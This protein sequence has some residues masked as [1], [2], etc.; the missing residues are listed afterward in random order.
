M[1]NQII[2]L[3]LLPAPSGYESARMNKLLTLS[4]ELGCKCSKD[5][6]GNLVARKDA[7]RPTGQR[8]ALIAGADETGFIVTDILENGSLAFALLGSGEAASLLF[9]PVCFLT[10][11]QGVLTPSDKIP[12]AEDGKYPV[13]KMGDLVIDIGAKNKAEAAELVRLGEVAVLEPAGAQLCDRLSGKSVS[14]SVSCSVLLRVMESICL[15]GECHADFTFVFAAQHK[16]GQRGAQAVLSEISPAFALFIGPAPVQKAQPSGAG[17]VGLGKGPV[18]K[19]TDRNIVY[20]PEI[21]RQLSDTAKEQKIPVQL[22]ASEEQVF[23]PSIP[24]M[25]AAFLGFPLRYGN[26]M[27][28]MVDLSDVEA[29]TKLLLAVVG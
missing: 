28:E 11:L 21:V 18:I 5:A 16:P 13:T 7:H 23:V 22:I 15:G 20:S 27:A 3:S 25:R 17:E 14:S 4:E 8:F 26:T 9:A 24:D 6:V 29:L 19:L 2:E 12:P 1:L 10:G